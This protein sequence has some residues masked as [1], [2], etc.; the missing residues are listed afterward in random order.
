MKSTGAARRVVNKL[1]VHVIRGAP[2]CCALCEQP[3]AAIVERC[4]TGD[5]IVALSCGRCGAGVSVFAGLV[6][7]T[8]RAS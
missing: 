1:P 4:P 8:G 2:A 5:V 3:L 7:T 6:S